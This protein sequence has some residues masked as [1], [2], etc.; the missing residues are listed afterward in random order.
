MDAVLIVCPGLQ[1]PVH[2]QRGARL[3]GMPEPRTDAWTAFVRERLS[4][5]PGDV[6]ARMAAAQLVPGPHVTALRSFRFL[7][8]PTPEV[9][10]AVFPGR[11]V[12]D[13]E[14]FEDDGRTRAASTRVR[15]SRY[16]CC[17]T[18]RTRWRRVARSCASSFQP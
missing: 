2:F 16:G 4:G 18:A 1:D 15:S 8:D 3:E 13:R 10:A 14:D 5:E 6:A 7:A 12:P 17:T 11:P 9:Y